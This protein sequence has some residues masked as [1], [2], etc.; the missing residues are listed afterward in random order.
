MRHI[1]FVASTTT[2]CDSFK[3]GFSQISGC[4]CHTESNLMS[5]L[6]YILHQKVDTVL[7]DLESPINGALELIGV[8]EKRFSQIYRIIIRSYQYQL[9]H[10]RMLEHANSSFIQPENLVGIRKIV[11]HLDTFFSVSSTTDELEIFMEQ[12]EVEEVG[13]NESYGEDLSD[14]EYLISLYNEISK[15]SCTVGQVLSKI[16]DH[17]E[18]S[19]LI[20]VR[21]N[22][23]HY[24][25]SRRVSSVERAIKLIG[26]NGVRGVLEDR[27]GS[28]L[29]DEML[30]L[31]A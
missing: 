1:L 11:S 3:N 20:L 17:F 29:K 23:S 9:K 24:G 27:L 14:D 21:I 16:R 6:R 26:L 12:Q 28:I 25:L 19:E 13:I 5:A 31:V 7:V 2:R 30:P 4:V 15:P 22:S 10:R 18:L 8:L